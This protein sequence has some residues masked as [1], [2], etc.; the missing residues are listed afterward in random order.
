MSERQAGTERLAIHAMPGHLIRRLHQQSTQ[1]FAA[2][3]REAGIDITSVQFAAMDALNSHPGID[4][5][6][7]AA[8]IAYDR[9]TIGGVIDR[10]EAKGILE[11]A[12]SERDRRARVVRLTEDGRRMHARL[13]PI[14]RQVQ[15]E[16]LAGI[17]SR[18]RER[19]T[20][21]LERLIADFGGVKGESPD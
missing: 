12:V 19:F 1:I 20:V 2:R 16:I 18:D 13:L 4:Q 7:V 14:V 10:L 15:D 21:L 3:M 11:R 8:L 5:A 17:G 9:A 6:G